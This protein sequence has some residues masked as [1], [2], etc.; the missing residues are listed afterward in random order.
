M[1][2]L[3]I[4]TSCDEI[5][6]GIVKNGVEVIENTIE[7]SIEKHKKTHGVIPEVAARDATEKIYSTVKLA[8]KNANLKFNDIDCLAVTNGPGLPGSLLVGIESAR[9]LAY[10]HNKKLIPVHHILGHVFANRLEEDSSPEFPVLVLTV[11]G[12]HNHL[13]LW[14]SEFDFELIGQ[15]ID[16]AAGEAF[17]KGARILDLGFPGGPIISK[18]AK[19][20]KNNHD[21]PITMKNSQDFNFSFSGLKTALMYKVKNLKEINKINEQEIKNLCNSYQEAIC[22]SL[23][24]KLKKAQKKFSVK[25]IHLSGGV[26]ANERLRNKIYDFTKKLNINFRYPKKLNYCTDNGVMIAG[27][28]FWQQKNIKKN[29]NF[30]EVDIFLNKNSLQNYS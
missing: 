1:I 21:L 11:S 6:V 26:S 17:D 25:E 10:I 8:L 9:T 24:L 30:E 22:D 4:E 5:A 14:K 13:I 19:E 7:S 16:D 12:G 28:A 23:I 3:G 15:T 18:L 27:A 29:W 20:G 2:I